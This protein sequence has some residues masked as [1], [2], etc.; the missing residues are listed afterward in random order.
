MTGTQRGKNRPLAWTPEWVTHRREVAEAGLCVECEK[1]PA[2]IAWGDA[3]AMTHGGGERRC[4]VCVYGPQIR[5]A[6]AR[7][8]RIPAL[9][10][11]LIWAWV[12]RR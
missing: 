6:F 3:L 11:R 12:R 1:R 9:T 5:H 2:S 8:V 4:G 10:A 7:A